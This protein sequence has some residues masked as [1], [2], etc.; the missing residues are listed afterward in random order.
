MLQA[1]VILYDGSEMSSYGVEQIGSVLKEF[2]KQGSQ[3]CIFVLDDENIAKKLVKGITVEDAKV[4]GT[5]PADEAVVYLG[6]TFAK[7]IKDPSVLAVHLSSDI[8][9][10]KNQLTINAIKILGSGLHKPSANVAKEYGFTKNTYNTIDHI[11]NYVKN[12]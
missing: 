12:M 4:S 7:V 6:T 2:G 11:Y 5:N 9:N 3:P 10:K 8:F 1:I